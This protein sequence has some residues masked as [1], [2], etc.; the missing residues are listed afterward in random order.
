M[1]TFFR[2]YRYMVVVS[3][4]N[5]KLFD[6]MH[7]FSGSS[8]VFESASEWGGGVHPNWRVYLI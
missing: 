5:L 2:D 1:F 7:L 3:L 4:E 6:F 8:F